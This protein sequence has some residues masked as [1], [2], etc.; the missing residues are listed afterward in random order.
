[1]IRVNVSKKRSIDFFLFKKLEQVKC[2]CKIIEDFK[3][4]LVE[5][6]KSSKIV[7]SYFGD[8][9]TF[10]EFLVDKGVEFNC[11]LQQF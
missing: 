3:I 9:K 11:N 6:K 5:D 10:I 4:S 1:M 8:I 7:E 2:I